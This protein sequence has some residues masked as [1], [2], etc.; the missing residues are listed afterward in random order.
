[1]A[2]QVSCIH[3]LVL[4]APCPPASVVLPSPH[5]VPVALHYLSCPTI[6]ISL[7]GLVTWGLSP[8]C[9]MSLLS[10]GPADGED[11]SRRKPDAG[12]RVLSAEVSAFLPSQQC[13]LLGPEPADISCPMNQ[14]VLIF[15]LFFLPFMQGCW[16]LFFLLVKGNSFLQS[17]DTHLAKRLFCKGCGLQALLSLPIKDMDTRPFVGTDAS[18]PVSR[19]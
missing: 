11:S 2:A 12:L 5:R 17:T 6:S 13:L 14:A 7:P 16:W 4:E 3:I 19:I 1:M 8:I 18:R 9:P 15:Y 10:A